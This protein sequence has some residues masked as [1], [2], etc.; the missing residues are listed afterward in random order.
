MTVLGRQQAEIEQVVMNTR[1]LQ[2]TL[3]KARQTPALGKLLWAGP[4]VA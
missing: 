4:V 2:F 1:C 3:R